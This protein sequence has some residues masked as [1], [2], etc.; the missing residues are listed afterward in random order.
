MMEIHDHEV[1]LFIGD[2]ITDCKRDKT[3]A[4]DLGRGYAFLT[5]AHIAGLHP[6]KK[7]TLQ[8]H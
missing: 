5:A 1:I 2:S 3:D 7:L 4:A 8:R 6:E